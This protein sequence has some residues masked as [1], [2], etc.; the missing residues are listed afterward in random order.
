[1]GI[2]EN[3]GSSKNKNRRLRQLQQVIANY[4]TKPNRFKHNPCKMHT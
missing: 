4:S 1:M 3:G 2:M